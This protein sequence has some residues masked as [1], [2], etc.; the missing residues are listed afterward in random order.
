MK[1]GEYN[2]IL[3]RLERIENQVISLREL[4]KAQMENSVD[5]GFY[6]EQVKKLA[7]EKRE[8]EYQLLFQSKYTID[9]NGKLIKKDA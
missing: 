4:I 7:A 9:H 2:A 6:Q 3:Q 5:A 1:A 8:T